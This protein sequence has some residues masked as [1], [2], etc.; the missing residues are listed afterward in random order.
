MNDAQLRCFPQQHEAILADSRT[1]GFSM[2]SD[3]QTGALLRVLAA[4]KPCDRLLELGTG[5][6]L[7][8]SWILDGMDATATL[9]SIE[10]DSVFQAVAKRHL[11]SDE[12]LT[13][14][15]CDGIDYLEKAATES[16]DLIYADTWPG[17]YIAFDHTLR[18]LRRGGIILLDDMLPQPNWPADH[19][20]KVKGL[21]ARIDTLSP[22]E[23]HVVRQCW[24][25]GHI[26]IVKR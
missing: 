7:G 12:R 8:T 3:N 16:F 5:T 22:N 17:K 23:F 4:S 21:L 25:T 14:I 19:P 11:G 18:I 24:Y 2:P 1:L 6:G 15:N 20:P 9:V 10:L 26:L 13:L